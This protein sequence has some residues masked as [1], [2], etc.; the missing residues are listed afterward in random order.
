MSL[1]LIEWLHV[2]LYVS[3]HACT[4]AKCVC[5]ASFTHPCRLLVVRLSAGG[6]QLFTAPYQAGNS[7]WNLLELSWCCRPIFPSVSPSTLY[8]S[9]AWCKPASLMPTLYFPAPKVLQLAEAE[10]EEEVEKYAKTSFSALCIQH[11]HSM[12]VLAN[13]HKTHHLHVAEHH[14]HQ[15]CNRS[16]YIIMFL[17]IIHCWFICMSILA[18]WLICTPPYTHI[19]NKPTL[20][21]CHS[22]LLVW[23]HLAA[24]TTVGVLRVSVPW[25]TSQPISTAV[26]E[27]SWLAHFIFS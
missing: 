8:S 10:C 19:D 4:S 20:R 27:C 24:W 14:V 7:W 26:H 22:R 1:S 2:Y 11:T 12:K 13:L 3:A 25:S 18:F 17:T 9:G 15:T 6:S 5:F 23:P 16:R 21:S